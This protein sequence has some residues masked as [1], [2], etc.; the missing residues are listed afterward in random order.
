MSDKCLL[1]RTLP[2]LSH[3]TPSTPIISNLCLPKSVAIVLSDPGLQAPHI[4]QVISDVSFP[5]LRHTKDH[6]KPEAL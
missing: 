3:I 2:P 1:A 6:F 5:L 4:P